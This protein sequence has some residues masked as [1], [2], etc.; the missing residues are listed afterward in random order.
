M[1]TLAFQERPPAT[2]RPAAR[3]RWI[4]VLSGLGTVALLTWPV[5]VLIGHSGD[6]GQGQFATAAPV[7]TRT[8]TV[9]Q[10]VTSLSVASYG[11]P[12]QITAGPVHQVTVTEAIDSPGP[13]SGPVPVVTDTVSHGRL[14]LAAP[15][16]AGMNS[17]CSVGFTVTVPPGVAV[18]AVSDSGDIA[19]AGTAGADLDSGGGNVQ[20]SRIDGRLTVSSENGS[21]NVDGATSPAGANLDSGGG[22]VE[23][24]GV[25]GPLAV[26]SE[27]GDITVEGVTAAAGTDLDSGGGNVRASQIIGPLTV[28]SEDGLISVADVTAPTGANL[29]S[30]GG[31]VE[32]SAITGPLSIIS[33]D[34]A[35]TLNG[36]TGNLAADT[37]GGPITAGGVAAARA[38]VTTEDGSAVLGFSTAP[39]YVLV[40]T[41]GGPAQLTFDRVPATVLVDTEDGAATLN[42][43]GGPYAISAASDGGPQTVAVPSSVAA[44]NSLTVNTGGGPLQI[45]P[46]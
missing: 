30:G 24:T 29:N 14:T 45:G 4:W 1:R 31:E 15:A 37:G 26:T 12:I 7:M 6:G 39:G 33:E 22:N 43:P 17:D 21:I 23:A 44:H 3:G 8:I 5:V 28:T 19:V 10:P 11:A 42:V 18:T 25:S 40:D 35:V 36:L 41:G 32:A 27:D 34:G 16:C 2:D 13:G 9:T 46:R 20:A 38:S